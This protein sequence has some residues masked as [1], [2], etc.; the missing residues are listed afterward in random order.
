M[1]ER[2][3]RPLGHRASLSPNE[4]NP[5]ALLQQHAASSAEHGAERRGDMATA[6]HLRR[7]DP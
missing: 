3:H 4:E 6:G 7:P 2:T 5:T 1:T